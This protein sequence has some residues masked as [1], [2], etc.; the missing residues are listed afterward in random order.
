M[1]SF[2]EFKRASSFSRTCTFKVNG[3]ATALTDFVITAQ[4][5]DSYGMKLIT[6]F[7]VIIDTDQ[8]TNVGK[9]TLT[10]A[11]SDTSG[12]PLGVLLLDIRIE[13][14]GVATYSDTV[15]LPVVER[16]TQL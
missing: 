13:L 4:L 2:K 6:D 1:I 14:A 5:R 16:I 9:F 8:T 7:E 12:W 15:Q 3:V 11:D 10:P